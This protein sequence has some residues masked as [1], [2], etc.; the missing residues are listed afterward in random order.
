MVLGLPPGVEAA[1]PLVRLGAVMF[2]PALSAV[3]HR[4]IHKPDTDGAEHCPACSPV[5]T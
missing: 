5:V 2:A 3:V 1:V 4:L